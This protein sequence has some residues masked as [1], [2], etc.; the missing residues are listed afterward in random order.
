MRVLITG[1]KGTVAPVLAEAC[2]AT[3]HEVVAWDRSRFPSEDPDAAR[4]GM[5]DFRADAFCHLATG[6][7]EWAGTLAGLAAERGMPFLFTSSVSVFSGLQQGPHAI[8]ATPHPDDDYGRYKLDAEK[9]VLAANPDAR[10]ARIGWQIGEDLQGNQMLAH[11]AA[12]QQAQGR[13]DASRNWFQA[14][15]FLQDTAQGL[16]QLL[17]LDEAGLYHLDSNPGLSFDR[18]AQALAA[19]FCLPWT[20][21]VREE[22]HL[23]NRLVDARLSMPSLRERLSLES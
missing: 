17:E 9:R 11:L 23:D 13:V 18:I 16:L 6:P 8:E 4:A 15:S 1:M 21:A 12:Q 5:D 10:I 14:C 2:R 22:P 19:R 3:G 20:V 7:A